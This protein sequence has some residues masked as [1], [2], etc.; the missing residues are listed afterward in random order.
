MYIAF[1][2]IRAILSLSLFILPWHHKLLWRHQ[3]GR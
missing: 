2:T 1:Q 3:K